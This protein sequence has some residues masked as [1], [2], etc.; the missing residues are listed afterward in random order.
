MDNERIYEEIRL[1]EE[2]AT[3]YE[4]N[5][6]AADANAEVYRAQAVAE[7]A[8]ASKYFNMAAEKDPSKYSEL[9]YKCAAKAN[10]YRA[11]ADAEERKAAEYREKA[12]SERAAAE[13]YR[14]QLIEGT[15]DNRVAAGE[16]LAI[17]ED[18]AGIVESEDDSNNK[19]QG[20][21]IKSFVAGGLAVALLATGAWILSRE[22]KKGRV[23]PVTA[24]TA[25]TQVD[26]ARSSASG[27]DEALVIV[28]ATP[29]PTVA[30]TPVPTVAPTPVPTEE[31]A[32]TFDYEGPVV[33]TEAA[34]EA[35]AE[36]MVESDYVVL[37]T[38]AFEALTASRIKD[39]KDKGITI[40]ESDIVKFT[41]IVNNDKL[42]QDNPEL[43]ASIKG[44]QTTDE[45]KQDGYK[46]IGAY[47]MYNY[48]LYF[49]EGNSN[50]FI[51]IS[52][53]IFDEDEKA[54]AIEIEN[55]VEEIAKSA[56]NTEEMNAL[57]NKLIK[58]MLNP[59]NELS[60]VES[61]VGFGL[62]LVLE[63]VR[64]LYS[65]SKDFMTSRL[66]ETNADLIK[67]IVPYAGDEQEYVD[68]ALLTGYVRDINANLNEC[69][70]GTSRSK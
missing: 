11:K 13:A 18:D 62:Q 1:V 69:T 45:M 30:P 66:N 54:K 53:F 70:K 63:P 65:M 49:A 56:S 40:K 44:D 37:T 61:G 2:K 23:M 17:I 51:K 48:N 7:D 15:H 8:K 24:S 4:S 27:Y 58:D 68:N 46:V 55:R 20:F 5:A 28:E 33:V 41:A 3:K 64:G 22:S 14:S 6:R 9:A 36:T 50:N 43:L 60:Y 35:A 21:S 39:A 19:K 59:T 42:A 38:D 67:Y 31:P 25:Y 32:Y 52:P 29:V 16:E 57:V 34:N 26:D 47:T 10:E 12:E